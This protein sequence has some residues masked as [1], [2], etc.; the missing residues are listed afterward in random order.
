MTTGNDTRSREDLLRDLVETLEEL[1]S[2]WDTDHAGPI[3][4]DTRLIGDLVFES[5]DVVQLIVAIEERYGRRDLPFEELLM[6]DGRY[7]DEIRVGDLVDFLH[8]RLAAAP[9]ADP[10]GNPP[11]GGR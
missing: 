2:D 10:A 6:G 1:T 7:V 4:A 8:G 9:A 3:D 5:I 11:G